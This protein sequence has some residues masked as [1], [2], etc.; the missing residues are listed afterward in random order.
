MFFLFGFLTKLEVPRLVLVYAMKLTG[1]MKI[2]M[3]VYLTVKVS[4]RIQENPSEILGRTSA[5]G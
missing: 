1:I 4:E 5:C 2:G 3:Q